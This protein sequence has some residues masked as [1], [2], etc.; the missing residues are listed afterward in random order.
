MLI[1]VINDLFTTTLDDLK[2]GEIGIDERGFVYARI[3]V[4]NP[5]EVQTQLFKLD[6][7]M[8]QYNNKIR[9]TTRVRVLAPDEK[10]VLTI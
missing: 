1:E 8:G 9:V 10:V 5:K 4:P 2:P 3:Y 7:M 6:D